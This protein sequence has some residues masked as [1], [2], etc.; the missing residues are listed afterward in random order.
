[1]H[2]TWESI[3]VVA[4]DLSSLSIHT[5]QSNETIND[6]IQENVTNLYSVED[7]IKKDIQSLN[8]NLN[9][10]D[11]KCAL[12]NEELT[13]INYYVKYFDKLKDLDIFILENEQKL[14]ELKQF[15]TN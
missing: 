8:S 2:R 1:M 5:Q 13:K 6:T 15:T 11:D 4:N 10:T 14:K 12:M 3:A 7:N 9:A